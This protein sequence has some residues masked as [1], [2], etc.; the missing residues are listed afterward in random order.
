M[1]LVDPDFE[2]V[3]AIFFT[4]LAVVLQRVAAIYILDEYYFTATITYIHYFYD[5]LLL[6]YLYDCC[7][8]LPLLLQLLLLLYYYYYNYYNYPEYYY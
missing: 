3:E 8:I 6:L 1:L 2:I 4:S 7:G 5:L